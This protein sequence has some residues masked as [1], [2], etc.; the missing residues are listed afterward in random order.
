MQGRGP[1][2]SDGF[3]IA[4]ETCALDMCKA[5]YVRDVVCFFFFF[6][7]PFFW[8][9]LFLFILSFVVR[10]WNRFLHGVRNSAHFSVF[11]PKFHAEGG[12]H[13]FQF[14]FP[15]FLLEPWTMVLILF[16]I[17]FKMDGIYAVTT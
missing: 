4:S 3:C 12:A 7:A 5:E 16:F 1:N 15:S 13:C 9:F 14:F 11:F 17:V 8:F 10:Q 2:G 6:F